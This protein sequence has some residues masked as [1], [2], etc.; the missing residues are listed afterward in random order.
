MARGTPARRRKPAARGYRP[1]FNT[2]PSKKRSNLLG[3]RAH[4]RTS[5]LALSVPKAV[6]AINGQGIN[7]GKQSALCLRE[8]QAEGSGLATGG[9]Q[10]PDFVHMGARLVFRRK[11]LQRDY[12]CGQRFR[13]NPFVV[14]CDS[15]SWHPTV[16]LISPRPAASQGRRQ[17]ASQ[18]SRTREGDGQRRRRVMVPILSVLGPKSISMLLAP[19]PS[20][21]PGIRIDGP[22]HL[23]C[24]ATFSI[25]D[26]LHVL[27]KNTLVGA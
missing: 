3:R 27:S 26:N 14:A 15:L 19:R 6:F 22:S 25:S 18:S 5:L 8:V 24:A 11:L 16:P 1:G 23:H 7:V 20:M 12:R 10:L 13:N 17:D 2:L 4:G 21:A 9:Q